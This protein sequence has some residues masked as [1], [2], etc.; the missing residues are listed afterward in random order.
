[1]TSAINKRRTIIVIGNGMVCQ[2]FCERLRQLGCTEAIVVFGEEPRPAYDRVKLTSYYEKSSADELLMAPYQWYVDNDIE[3]ALNQT[4]AAVD[5]AAKTVSTATGTTR[6]YDVLVFASG[7]AAFVPP[8]PGVDKPGV[9]VYR[10]IED[11]DAIRDYAKRCSHATVMGGGLLGLEAAKAVYDMGLKATV[12]EMA[13]RL[14]PRQLDPVGG[15]LLKERIEALGIEVLTGFATK[16]LVGETKLEGI[17][18]QNDEILATDMLVIS[19]GIKPRDEV[20]RAAGIA[21]GPRGGIVVN[22]GLATSAPD[23]YAIGECALHS[24]MIYGLIAP[25]WD[26]ADVLAKNLS[27]QTASFTGADMST[28]LKLL[29]VDVA[30]F[31]DAF[32]DERG[33]RTIV[34]Q[35]LVS[36]VYK[37]LVL[38]PEGKQLVGG[39]LVGEAEEFTALSALV[40]AG[41]A[42]PPKPEALILG[43]RGGA[44]VELELPDEAQV[45]SCNNISK[46]EI[47]DVV[48]EGKCANFE[49][50]KS[51]T[52]AGSTCGGCAPLVTKLVNK[53]LAAMGRVLKNDLCEHFAFT[54]QEL[55]HIIRVKKLRTFEAVLADSGKGMGCEICKPTIASILASTF[56]E[57][58]L[59]HASLQ[60]S[61]DRFLANIQRQGTYSV[62]PRIPG[63]EI[64]PAA[65]ISI[66]KVAEK[67]GLYTKITGGQRIDLFGARVEQLPDIWEELI[68]AGLESGHA[69]GKALRTVK[70]CVGTTWCR[71]GVQDSVGF[72]IRVENRYKGLR[73]PHKLKS[74]VSGCIRECAEA[75]S[76]DFGLIATDKGW[77]LFVCGNGGSQPRHADLFASDLDEDTAIKYI[78]RFLMYYIA[79]ADRL[80]RTARWVE[81]LEGGL[82]H[83]KDVIIHDK[84]G[85]CAQLEADM[86]YLVDTYRC[87]WEEVV[88]NPARREQFRYFANTKDGSDDTLEWVEQRAQK[89]PADWGTGTR[90][91]QP[92]RRRLKVITTQWVDVGSTQDFMVDGGRAVKYGQNQLAVFYIAATGK[93][94]ATQNVCPHKKDMVLSRGIVGDAGGIPKVACPQHKKTFDLGTGAGLNDADYH[95]QTFPVRV[96]NGRVLIELPDAATVEGLIHATCHG[97]CEDEVPQAEV[98]AAE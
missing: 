64:T 78:D 29:G 1:M 92:P 47:C 94:Y 71:F 53:T 63:G 7:S 96:D 95:I 33:G 66:G 26:M 91:N 9:F 46:G 50:V 68:A 5:V 22:D 31:G 83:L 10:T 88:N 57:P 4:V 6:E 18:Q 32:A 49:S 59:E 48:R 58:I 75:Q 27:G 13:P 62:V 82:E 3:L 97:S 42:L 45:C 84:L 30:S 79:T 34:F 21:V 98:T 41:G 43:G 81:S 60:D 86:Q 28:K 73:A 90:A 56:N 11:L 74:A 39:I 17:R 89:R 24:G 40:K 51:C 38:D 61:N 85:I 35:D 44:A 20:A 55:Y 52:K 65:L 72:A 37:K 69:Y 23:V 14:M 77:N 16:D 54:R 80:T 36:G 93:Y 76:K 8:L 15:R 2:R 70:S 19:A 67:Y 12:I 87:E 25:G